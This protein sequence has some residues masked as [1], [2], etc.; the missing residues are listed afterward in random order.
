MEALK[1]SIYGPDISSA[2][3]AP[4]WM[5]VAASTRKLTSEP[6]YGYISSVRL[7]ILRGATYSVG[8]EGE[9]I[10]LSLKVS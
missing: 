5:L 3:L 6:M 9:L 4:V 10:V 2:A 8:S 7:E 1:S